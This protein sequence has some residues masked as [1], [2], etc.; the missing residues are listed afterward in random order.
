MEIAFLVKDSI[1][2][3][4]FCAYSYFSMHCAHV[5]MLV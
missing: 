4:I 2:M 3:D 1:K 5:M